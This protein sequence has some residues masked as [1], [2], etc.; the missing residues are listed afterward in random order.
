MRVHHAKAALLLDLVDEAWAKD[1]LPDDLLM[2]PL[3]MQVDPETDEQKV[4]QE[5]EVWADLGLGEFT[6]S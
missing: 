5:D 3:E 2:L 4:P 6:E 1:T